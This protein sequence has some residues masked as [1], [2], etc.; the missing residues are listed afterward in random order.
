M[1]H[2][3]VDSFGDDSLSDLLVYNN[4]DGPGVNVEDGTC[5]AMIVFVGHTL[6]DGS[7]DDNINDISDFVGGE[8]LGDVNGAVLFESLFELVSGS[9]FV[10]VA[11]SHTLCDK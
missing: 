1:F 5:A 6:M 7:V 9:A 8:G 11:V 10:S 3:D 2:S 4:S